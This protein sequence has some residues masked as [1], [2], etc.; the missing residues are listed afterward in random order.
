MAN[1]IGTPCD[2][3]CCVEKNRAILEREWAKWARI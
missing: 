3:A 1:V 2:I